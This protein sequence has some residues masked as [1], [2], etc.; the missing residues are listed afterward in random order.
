METF[1]VINKFSNEIN[2]KYSKNNLLIFVLI[3]IS[4]LVIFSFCVGNVSAASG[5]S[6]YVNSS[7]GN[8]LSYSQSTSFQSDTLKDQDYNFFEVI[9]WK[10]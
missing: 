5:D 1:I 2:W 3:L 10:N 6:I 9:K 8:D 7:S 4:L